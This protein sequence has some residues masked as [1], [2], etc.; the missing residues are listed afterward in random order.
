M[1]GA[2]GRLT[3]C[4][5]AGLRED[6]VVDIHRVISGEWLWVDSLPAPGGGTSTG[7]LETAVG[8]GRSLLLESPALAWSEPLSAGIG[9]S[10]FVVAS[11]TP[12]ARG[13][14]C[15]TQLPSL[16][17]SRPTSSCCRDQLK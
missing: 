5:S 7:E 8:L 1:R 9:R 2:W 13:P 3:S 4:G 12:R 14:K 16:S 17:S 6:R 11:T 10:V 15:T